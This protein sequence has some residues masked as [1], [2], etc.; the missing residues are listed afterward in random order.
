MMQSVTRLVTRVPQRAVIALVR[1]YQMTISP[2]LGP[3]CRFTPSCSQ[4]MIEA[5][6]RYGVLRGSWRGLRRI[7]RC[8][9]FHPGGHDPP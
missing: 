1:I 2:L 6:Q 4:Y 8:H 9:P 3:T 7:L 5:V